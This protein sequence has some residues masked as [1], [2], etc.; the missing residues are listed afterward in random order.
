[1]LSNNTVFHTPF[2]SVPQE[3][4]LSGMTA[5]VVTVHDMLPRIHPEYFTAETI[6]EFDALLD[7]LLPSDHVICVS[8]ST[9]R[10]FLRCHPSTPAEQVHVTPLAASPDLQ[11]VT[12][13]ATLSAL[14]QQLGL[15]SSDQVILSLCTLEPR[16]NLTSL[17]HSFEQLWRRCNG[18]SIKLVLAGSLGWKT[19]SL[20]EQLRT[21]PAAE[22][23]VVTGHIPESQL[24]SLYSL[25]DVF[26]YPRHT[27]V[28]D[29][30]H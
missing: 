29:F 7:Q 27:K 19:T 8:E 12:D 20:T 14:R 9:R 25:A 30:H 21:S 5:V 16:K 6:R 13:E 28:L 22:A 26:V 2:Q 4:R 1:M 17:I 10:D 18:S 23:I 11:P 24:A 3:V 15:K